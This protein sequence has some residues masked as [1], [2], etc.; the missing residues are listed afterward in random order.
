[1]KKQKLSELEKDKLICL[2]RYYRGEK[3]NPYTQEGEDLNRGMLWFYEYAW[4]NHMLQKKENEGNGSLSEYLSDYIN[5]GLRDFRASDT[6]PITLKA[7]IFN[8]YMRGSMDGDTKPFMNFF[9]KYY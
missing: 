6:I 7:L 1:M 9:N 5:A 8:R 2:C 3:D 4:V